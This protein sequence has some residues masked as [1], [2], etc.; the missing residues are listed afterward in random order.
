MHP[1][2]VMLASDL[3]PGLGKANSHEIQALEDR[4]LLL[5]IER[6]TE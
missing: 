6:E 4:G 1:R 2:S 3:R 5:M